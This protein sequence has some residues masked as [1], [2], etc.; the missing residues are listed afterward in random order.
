V[1]LIVPNQDTNPPSIKY[2]DFDQA[3]KKLKEGWSHLFQDVINSN[4]FILGKQLRNFESEFAEYLECEFVVGVGN[5]LDAIEIALKSLGIGPGDFVAVPTH[6]FI[7]T[8]LAVDRVGANIVPVGVNEL[9][10]LD[11]EALE[12]TDKIIDAVI[13]VHMHGNMVDMPRLVSWARSKNIKV[14]EDC[15]QAHGASLHGVK[16]GL[17]G[18]VGCYS[19][20]PT[21]NL[22]ALGDSGALVTN[23]ASVANYAISYRSYGSNPTNKYDHQMVGVNSRMDEVQAAIL[24]LNLKELELWNDHRKHI[25]KAYQ[26]S[27]SG[28]LDF[29]NSQI[30]SVFHHFVVFLNNRDE[31]RSYLMDHGIQTEIHYPN[32]PQR[33]FGESPRVLHNEQDYAEKFSLM[34]LSIP[35]NQWLKM[36]EVAY[37]IQVLTK[38]EFLDQF[39][40]I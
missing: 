27:L 19:F 8:W 28:K 20:Y 15:A 35:L 16:A 13:P 24:S 17:W 25:A 36:Q 26:S 1:D 33:L 40:T 38:K 29:L 3:P 32:L 4:S 6:T 39:S 34:G 11:V 10:L 30:G 9:G 2:F 23:S 5:G 22:G 37:I 14:I 31:A 21:K 12:R 18:D 7:A